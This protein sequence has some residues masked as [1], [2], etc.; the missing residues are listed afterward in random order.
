MLNHSDTR[1]ATLRVVNKGNSKSTG[2]RLTGHD[3][4]L[5]IYK[6]EQTTIK[7]VL[8]GGTLDASRTVLGVVRFFDKFTITIGM[9]PRDP[10]T[11]E[12]VEG[13]SE[14][15]TCFYKHAIES[16]SSDI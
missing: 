9:T 10:D 12:V 15:L 1:P 13:A 6:K 16:F 2:A 11:G 8:T 4:L 14:G 5:N 7:V 3:A